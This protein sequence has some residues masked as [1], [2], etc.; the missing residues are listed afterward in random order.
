M[1]NNGGKIKMSKEI[2][3][4]RVCKNKLEEKEY[5][6][7]EKLQMLYP[8]FAPRIEWIENAA[9]QVMECECCGYTFLNLGENTR[10]SKKRVESNEYQYPF[11]D[12]YKGSHEAVKCYRVAMIYNWLSCNRQA[13]VWFLYAGVLLKQTKEGE[14]CFKQALTLLQKEVQG[15]Y[16]HFEISVAYLNVLRLLELFKTAIS[17]GENMKDSFQGLEK[18]LISAILYLCQKGDSTWY[19]YFEILSIRDRG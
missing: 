18:E 19:E 5:S 16:Q 9:K 4:C 10:I 1:K 11:G 17:I 8:R 15:G 13:A 2:F 14:K 12:E 7:S 6:D 3:Y